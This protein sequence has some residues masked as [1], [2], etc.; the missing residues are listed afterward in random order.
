MKTETKWSSSQREAHSVGDMG[1][2]LTLIIRGYCDDIFEIKQSSESW[3]ILTQSVRGNDTSDERP[4]RT[5]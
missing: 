4:E 2:E 5:F 3:G 1:M